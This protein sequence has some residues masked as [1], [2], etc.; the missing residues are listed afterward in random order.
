M[1]YTFV[2][3][4]QCFIK[5]ELVILKY[6]IAKAFRNV[7]RFINYMKILLLFFVFLNIDEVLIL[8]L[9]FIVF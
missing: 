8:T 9:I 4:L 6:K 2:F 3:T 7:N 1:F 5:Q